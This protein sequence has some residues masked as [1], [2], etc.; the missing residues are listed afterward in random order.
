MWISKEERAKSQKHFLDQWKEEEDMWTDQEHCFG[1]VSPLDGQRSNCEPI[2]ANVQM[3]TLL[4][5][6]TIFDAG[7][8]GDERFTFILHL[9]LSFSLSSKTF[10]FQSWLSRIVYETYPAVWSAAWTQAIAW[11]TFLDK[12]WT[13]ALWQGESWTSSTGLQL[14][15]FDKVKSQAT[16]KVGISICQV[17]VTYVAYMWCLMH[18][19]RVL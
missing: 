16:W 17:Y 18:W 1:A 15:L 13:W 9:S 3:G 10:L 7:N 6:V 2:C 12:S 8:G 11:E 14:N 19:L 5:F 4:T